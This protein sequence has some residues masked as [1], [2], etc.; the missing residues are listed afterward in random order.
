MFFKTSGFITEDWYPYF[1]AVRRDGE[2]LLE[3]YEDGKV[4]RTAKK[5]YEIISKEAM[6]LHEIKSR[7]GFGKEDKSAF[8][9]AM[10]EL[11]MGMYIT[12]TGR[13][14]KRSQYGIEYGWSSTVFA[15]VEDFWSERGFTIPELD[16][17]KSYEKIRQ[18][19]LRLN[20]AAEEKT[21]HKF[22]LGK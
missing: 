22:I 12:M 11:Q 6:A 17:G 13:K 21:I 20:P 19:I 14:Q 5:I 4:S 10:I 18:Q 3:A 7:G 16:A 1:Y 2:S 9:R 8:D 15:T